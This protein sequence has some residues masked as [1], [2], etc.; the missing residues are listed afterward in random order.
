MRKDEEEGDGQEN[1]RQRSGDKYDWTSLGDD[2]G[3]AERIL[4]HRPQ[5]K[6]QDK[7]S[8]L[9]FELL[10]EKPR[11]PEDHHQK[12][13]KNAVF[14]AVN[15]DD[16][17]EKDQGEQDPIRNLQN[18]HP[19]GDQGEVQHEEQPIPDVHA[20]HRS[21][22]DIGMLAEKKRTGHYIMDHQSAQKQTHHRIG[23]DPQNEQGD[24][25][26]LGARIIG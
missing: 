22:E 15:T 1:Q 4:C 8:H 13:V 25:I 23:R 14:H 24:E 7:R 21:P 5:Y 10:E 16:A 18:L 11:D 9:V 12:Y 19:E 2:Q 17:E 6:S 3:L 26:T 20:H